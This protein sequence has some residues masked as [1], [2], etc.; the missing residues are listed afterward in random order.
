MKTGC[1][2]GSPSGS[3]GMAWPATWRRSD[4][5]AE[6]PTLTDTNKWVGVSVG[7]LQVAESWHALAFGFRVRLRM[8]DTFWSAR[9]S[10]PIR[11][12]AAGGDL[13]GRQLLV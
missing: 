7:L 1:C 2:A 8:S 13:C 5:A 4:G 12:S 3:S 6:R 9:D 10:L 11:L